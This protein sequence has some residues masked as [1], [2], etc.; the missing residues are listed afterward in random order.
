MSRDHF[1]DPDGRPPDLDWLRHD[2]VRYGT[3]RVDGGEDHDFVGMTVDDMLYG[4]ASVWRD[5]LRFVS[6]ERGAEVWRALRL[7]RFD[8]LGEMP[9]SELISTRWLAYFVC[10]CESE[11]VR[12][13]PYDALRV[14]MDT[15]EPG[16]GGFIRR[17]RLLGR[18]PLHDAMR[19]ERMER[20][21]EWN[22]SLAAGFGLALWLTADPKIRARHPNYVPPDPSKGRWGL[23]PPHDPEDDDEPEYARP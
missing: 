4:R 3:Y 9:S 15:G 18:C 1:F 16:W 2:G 23:W 17:T 22:E 13:Y 11:R 6:G 5:G 8:C 20:R 7:E 12:M 19:E 10:G 21:R 14:V